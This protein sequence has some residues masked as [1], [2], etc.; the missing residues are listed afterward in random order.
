MGC[1]GGFGEASAAAP[2]WDRHNFSTHQLQQRK[3]NTGAKQTDGVGT[4]GTDATVAPEVLLLNQGQVG[5]SAKT[6]EKKLPELVPSLPEQSTEQGALQGRRSWSPGRTG[7]S[8]GQWQHW[9]WQ[10]H[11]A[12]LSC[13]PP[14]PD[15]ALSCSCQAE[16][17]CSVVQ[18]RALAPWD[19]E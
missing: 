11:G 8:W 3:F 13:H 6:K 9:C 18:G 4:G 7:L 12:E 15:H 17:G 14:V 10:G 19:G 1:Y 2:A 16:P 5:S